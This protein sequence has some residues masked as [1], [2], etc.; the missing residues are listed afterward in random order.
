MATK[1]QVAR[2]VAAGLGTEVFTHE[3]YGSFDVT[4]TRLAAAAGCYELCST[5]LYPDVAHIVSYMLRHRDYDVLRS[6]ELMLDPAAP[7]EHD[8]LIMVHHG[9]NDFTLIDGTHRLLARWMLRLP[10]FS[11]YLVP[12]AAAIRPRSGGL[13]LASGEWGRLT[14]GERRQAVRQED[15]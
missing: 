11:F 13:R 6:W 1:S 5:P 4:A 8:P 7:W 10:D 14:V 9:E 15:R 2:Q 3:H 12:L